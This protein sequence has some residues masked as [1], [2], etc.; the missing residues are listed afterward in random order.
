MKAPTRVLRIPSRYAVYF[1][2]VN[3][4]VEVPHSRSL[5]LKELTLA[6][7]SRPGATQNAWARLIS[8]GSDNFWE[9]GVSRQGSDRPFGYLTFVDGTFAFVTSPDAFVPDVFQH[10][11][12]TYDGRY[13][14]LYRDGSLVATTDTGGKEVASLTSNPRIGRRVIY[15]EA[16]N[17]L[18]ASVYI[19]NRALSAEEVAYN[20]S[21]PENPVRSGLVLWLQAH[22][23]NVKDVDGDDRLEWIDLSGYGNHGKIYGATLVEVVKSPVRVLSPARVV[24]TV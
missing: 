15:A 22:P 24:P 2:G 21:N 20:Y 7:W 3:N 9:L 5:V 1:N 23:D 8:S 16:F 11:S 14:R 19:Y 12:F 17:G 6:C 4:Y 10:W 13:M 18:I